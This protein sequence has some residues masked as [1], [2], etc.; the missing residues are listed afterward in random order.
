MVSRARRAGSPDRHADPDRHGR[1]TWSWASR[2][3]SSSSATTPSSPTFRQEIP[4]CRARRDVRRDDALGND[5][6][7]LRRRLLAI[8]DQV[9]GLPQVE[10]GKLVV[11]GYCRRE[12]R[13]GRGAHR[14]GQRGSGRLP[15]PA[16]PAELADREDQHERSRLPRLG[17][18]DGAAGPCGRAGQGLTEAGADWQI[19]A[20]GNGMPDSP[21]PMP[22]RSGSRR[23][24]M[25]SLPPS[26]PGR[27]S[28]ACSRKLSA[29]HGCRHDQRGGCRQPADA[30]REGDRAPRQAL[31]R[32]GRAGDQRRGL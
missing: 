15:R 28:S 23:S 4:R 1:P 5:R 7:A 16:R 14:H 11:A 21:I 25:T 13:A 18:S 32:Q 10:D 6:V 12:V 2:S 19:H 20:Y 27:A 26:V 3:S 31:S 8:V 29:E 9:R 17:R 24:A 22:T 30:A